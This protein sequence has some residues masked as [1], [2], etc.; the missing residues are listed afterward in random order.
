MKRVAVISD[1][2]GNGVAL[3]AVL[4]DLDGA[5]AD[6]LVCLG[7]LA[8]GGAQPERVVDMVRSLELDA[9]FVLGNADDFLLTGVGFGEP[10]TERQRLVREWSLSRLGPERCDFIRS[11]Q[12]TVELGLDDGGAL[13]AFHGSPRSYDDIVLPTA[14]EAEF[15]AFFEEAGASFLCGG[16]IHV[17]W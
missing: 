12:P 9:F 8:Q 5:D 15:A 14:S 17:Q 6:A 16:H 7:D 13:L 1:V 10:V 4:A 11:F 2:H 3:Q